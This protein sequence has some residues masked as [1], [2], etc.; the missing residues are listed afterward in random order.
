MSKLVIEQQAIKL[1]HELLIVGEFLWNR[2]F[3]PDRILKK[4]FCEFPKYFINL[5]QFSDKYLEFIKSI[6][7]I[8]S[9]QPN[10]TNQR[11]SLSQWN[12]LIDGITTKYYGWANKDFIGST[13]YFFEWIIMEFV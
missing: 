3:L 7:N 1:H 11:I 5:I 12:N 4:R 8:L 9:D 2:F 13:K 10:F 6:Q